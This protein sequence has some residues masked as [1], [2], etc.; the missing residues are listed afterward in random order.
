MHNLIGQKDFNSEELRTILKDKLYSRV[1]AVGINGGEPFLKTDLLDCINA[2]VNMLPSLKSLNIISN[3]FFTDKIISQLT[4]IKK[5]C[6]L[7]SIKVNLS[8][9][10][11]GVKDMQ[12]FM[13]G[14][15]D[16]FTHVNQTIQAIQSR[17]N[18]LCDSLG[19]ICTLTRH[20]ITRIN[21][22]EIWA[23][24]T[25]VNVSYNIATINRR[26][27]NFDKF[28]H[29]SIFT[30]QKALFLAREFFYKLFL[31]TDS[32]KYFAIFLYLLTRKRYAPCEHLEC[33]GVTLTPD[34]Q[35][36]YCAT[37][38]KNLGN[39]Y[40]ESSYKIFKGNKKHL[41]ELERKFCGGCSHYIYNLS[42]SGL[43]LFRDEKIR[44]MIT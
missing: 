15:K 10:V 41:R 3:G 19:I 25:G 26:I 31:K 30:D 39:A 38:S 6:K 40:L 9:S 12:D 28:E 1:T 4:E 5:L 20:N 32:E 33:S 17:Q 34:M 42:P 22:V 36:G 11:D 13:R 23:E 37:Y 35:L 8:L 2:I 16:A 44:R 18:E 43:K 7:K 14:H 29:F 24:S 21:E 27:D